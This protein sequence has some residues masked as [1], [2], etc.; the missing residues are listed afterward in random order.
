MADAGALVERDGRWGLERETAVRAAGDGRAGRS[1][2][3]IDR[4]DAASREVLL[5]ASVIGRRFGLAL[6]AGVGGHGR[7]PPGRAA[8]AAAARPRPRGAP[9]ARTG[10]PLQARADPG[11]R[12]PHARRRAPARRCTRAPPTWLEQRYAD[13]LEEVY[14]LLA[15]HWLRAADDDRAAPYLALA[16][17]RAARNW[18]LDEAIEHYR[19]LLELLEQRGA[20]EQAAE[21]LFKLALALHTSMR[22]GEANDAYQRAFELWQ[23][24]AVRPAATATLHVRT[25]YVPRVADPT[26]AGWWADIRLCMQL[27]D[28]LVETGP[29]RDDPAVAGRTLGDRRRRPA[30]TGSICGRT[31]LVGRPTDDCA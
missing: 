6:L 31:R 12:L 27:F 26:R 8:R 23:P 20:A 19:A 10:V 14:G 24:A 16:G 5:A 7:R 29:E 28:R 17:D 22:F 1:S 3:R 9:L 15:H 13:A 4:L 2:A 30:C 25:T 11:G 18:A 21:V